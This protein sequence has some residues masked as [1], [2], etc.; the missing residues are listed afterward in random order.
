MNSCKTVPSLT[1][2]NSVSWPAFNSMRAGSKRYSVSRTVTRCSASSSGFSSAKTGGTAISTTPNPIARPLIVFSLSSTFRTAEPRS[3]PRRTPSSRARR[4]V[5]AGRIPAR[6]IGP[7]RAPPRRAGA[8]AT[9]TTTPPTLPPQR[10]PRVGGAPPPRL[11]H[12][13]VGEH[14]QG[15]A[16]DERVEV[17]LFQHLA[18]G[19][20]KGAFG[21]R[22]AVMYDD[23]GPSRPD[24]QHREEH[25]RQIADAR[26]N[27]IP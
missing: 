16:L 3:T 21:L 2:V 17:R 12:E 13:E 11:R 9:P 25:K 20:G 8:P 23:V 22:A 24:P 15:H 10:P 14:E 5:A 1:S 7:A 6:R 4:P 27:K 19:P 18:V 26:K